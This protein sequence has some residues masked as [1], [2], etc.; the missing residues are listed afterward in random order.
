M[1]LSM[2]D[3]FITHRS[4]KTNSVDTSSRRSNYKSK[5]ESLNRLLSTLQQ[6]LT[7]IEDLISFIFAVIRIAYEQDKSYKHTKRSSNVKPPFA[8]HSLDV[9]I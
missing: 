7:A 9:N 5:N 1:K 8:I 2:F 4:K 3:F 6:K